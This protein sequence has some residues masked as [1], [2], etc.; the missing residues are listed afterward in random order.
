[1]KRA[2]SFAVESSRKSKLWYWD[3]ATNSQPILYIFS[4]RT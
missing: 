4:W 3:D 2:L 1:M